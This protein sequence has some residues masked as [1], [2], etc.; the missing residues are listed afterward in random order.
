M[1]TDV[2]SGQ[3]YGGHRDQN[4]DAARAVKAGQDSYSESDGDGRMA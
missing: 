3:A 1:G 2:D 4:S